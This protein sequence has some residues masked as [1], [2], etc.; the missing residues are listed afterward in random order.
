[1]GR[2]NQVTTSLV[3][4]FEPGAYVIPETKKTR[5]IQFAIALL[6]LLT[7]CVTSSPKQV[8]DMPEP[9]FKSTS[10]PWVIVGSWE[11]QWPGRS[12]RNVAQVTMLDGSPQVE[13]VN[14]TDGEKYEVKL[15]SFQNGLLQFSLDTQ[16]S[17]TPNQYQLVF[18]GDELNGVVLGEQQTGVTWSRLSR[19]VEEP[20]FH[21]SNPWVLTGTW[22]EQWPS[23]R[24]SDV[25]KVSLVDGKPHIEMNDCTDGEKYEVKKLTFRQ[26]TLAFELYTPSTQNTLRYR[27]DF[28]GPEMVG[29]A[30]G[31]Q[32][33]SITW[34]R[35]KHNQAEDSGCGAEHPGCIPSA[36]INFVG[37]WSELWV[38]RA[39]SDTIEVTKPS[40]HTF[41]VKMVNCANGKLYH[42]DQHDFND[43]ILSFRV[44]Q[45]IKYR[46]WLTGNGDVVGETEV[47]IG[48]SEVERAER[49]AHG[50]VRWKPKDLDEEDFRFLSG[51]WEEFWSKE[52][53]KD[54]IHISFRQNHPYVKMRNCRTDA[55]FKIS[56]MRFSDGL[57]QF[58]AS[59]NGRETPYK[60]RVMASGV[61]TGFAGTHLV[62]WT[63][64]R[65]D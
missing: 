17:S 65:S 41:Q 47:L 24:C 53:C 10:N 60:L 50:K 28:K 21:T 48:E 1:M 12:C 5:F 37:N 40:D 63:K 20:V 19:A 25:A 42:I 29:E 3:F 55:P 61:I 36:L 32:R 35:P 13:I 31:N 33:K 38:D 22:E 14:C 56:E 45:K 54:P 23:R 6:W 46:V 51:D 39:C 58:M 62:T 9:S 15:A 43:G 8:S 49:T 16:S 11:E 44:D 59:I 57:M 27:L 64:K 2:K 4:V 26:G 30:V 7:G 52:L 18:R 34:K